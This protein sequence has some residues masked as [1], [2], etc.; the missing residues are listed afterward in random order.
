MESRANYDRSYLL[1]FAM[2]TVVGHPAMDLIPV[3]ESTTVIYG[4][5]D[6]CADCHG[7]RP[8]RLCR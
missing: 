2:G 6:R 1:G 8:Y 4:T 5:I 7:K 3:V